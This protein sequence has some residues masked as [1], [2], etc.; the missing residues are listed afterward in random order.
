MFV[1][2]GTL[3]EMT[4]K[5]GNRILDKVVVP[6]EQVEAQK[7]VWSYMAGYHSGYVRPQWN[8]RPVSRPKIKMRIVENE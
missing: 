6:V 3:I 1:E 2:A 8:G 5:E 7:T 4:L